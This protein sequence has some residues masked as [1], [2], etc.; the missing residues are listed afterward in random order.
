VLEASKS[1]AVR[2][3][4]FITFLLGLILRP[5]QHPMLNLVSQHGLTSP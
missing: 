3:I 4:P 1:A 2:I 5:S